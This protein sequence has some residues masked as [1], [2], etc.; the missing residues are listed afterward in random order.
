MI[1]SKQPDPTA[2]NNATQNF[3]NE[4][5]KVAEQTPGG[6]HQTSVSNSTK[7]HDSITTH[8]GV[9]V[10]E[11]HTVTTTGDVPETN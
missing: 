9:V 11:E 2:L 7:T 3:V 6:V 5:K 4:V 1:M 8:N 10:H